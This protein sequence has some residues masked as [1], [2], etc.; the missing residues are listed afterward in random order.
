MS[1]LGFDALG[2]WALGQLPS[3]SNFVL[4]AAQGSIALA[5][6]PVAFAASE[7][8]AA[9]SFVETGLSAGFKVTLPGSP[10]FHALAGNAA[11]VRLRQANLVGSFLLT[12]VAANMR[13]RL[14]ASNGENLLS[15]PSVP[16][17]ASLAS[18]PGAFA[19]AGSD[20]AYDRDHEAWV[21]RPLETMSWQLEAT[22]PPPAWSGAAELASAW[23]AHAQPGNAWIPASI[24]PEPWLDPAVRQ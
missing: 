2:R 8:I 11:T 12:G 1:L 6:Q 22:L 19:W 24:E 23:A 17:F 4:L 21:R 18:G 5:G 10:G 14:V 9:A 16:F 15:G 20:S 13:V 7:R 3:T